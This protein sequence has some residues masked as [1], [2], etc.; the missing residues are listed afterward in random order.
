M[1][2]YADM[3]I[4]HFPKLICAVFVG[5]GLIIYPKASADGVR[6]GL[7]LLFEAV[8]PSLF[9]FLVLSSYI[10][11]GETAELLATLF[12]KVTN[13]V[14]KMQKYAFMP[15]LM[16]LIGGYPVGAKTTAELYSK[17]KL[18]HNEAERLMFFCVNAGPAFTST[19]VGVAMLGSLRAGLI[20]YACAVLSS[21]TIGF[22][23]RFLS[24]GKKCSEPKAAASTPVKNY[25]FTSSVASGASA[26][27]N[28]S[29]WVLTFSCI[30]ALM[31]TIKI[32]AYPSI[33]IKAALEV[34][35][36]CRA[37]CGSVPLPVISA[38]LGFGGFSV[39]C[40]VL[41]Y[42]DSCKIELRR[43]ISARIINSALNAF[44]CS[45][46]VRIFPDSTAA[47]AVIGAGRASLTLS[48][49]LGATIIL[50]FMCAVLILEVD[51]REKI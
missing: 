30:S 21:M 10:A 49:S 31:S 1:K 27:F 17:G 18:T 14:F 35:T 46:F 23:C 37:A 50:L 6:E 36:G 45:Q 24:D 39:I 9:P 11:S 38:I 25:A 32:G 16:G 5:V 7:T 13:A 22:F 44:F 28:I 48:Y 12:G 40:Q 8:I 47:S 29:A 4:R 34:T 2:K 33:F 42:I 41:P 19:A 26:M 15:I 20:L 3:F 43:F 51:N